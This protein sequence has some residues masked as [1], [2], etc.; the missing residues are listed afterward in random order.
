MNTLSRALVILALISA[1][2]CPLHA[3][4]KKKLRNTGFEPEY[5]SQIFKGAEDAALNYGWLTPLQPKTGEK[6]PLVICLHGAG[7]NSRASAVMVR[8]DM[9]EKYPTFVMVPKADSRS[10]WARTDLIQRR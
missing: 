5:A 8:K 2:P 7:G 9:R 4:E 10:V 1:L 6:Y 3:Q